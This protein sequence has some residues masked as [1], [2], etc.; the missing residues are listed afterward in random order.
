MLLQLDLL[1]AESRLAVCPAAGP[2]GIPLGIAPKEGW[3]WR[4]FLLLAE[5]GL[6]SGAAGVLG[7]EAGEGAGCLRNAASDIPVGAGAAG[8]PF[9][10]G[11]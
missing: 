10:P 1:G 11:Q 3:S 7:A 6:A 2:V 4:D 5:K 9:Y 8:R